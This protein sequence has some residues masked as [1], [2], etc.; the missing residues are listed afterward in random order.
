MQILRLSERTE[1][2]KIRIDLLYDDD[3][4]DDDYVLLAIMHVWCGIMSILSFCECF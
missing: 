4:V 3:D 2:F 1:Q